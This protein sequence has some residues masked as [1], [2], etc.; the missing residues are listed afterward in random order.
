MRRIPYRQQ[1]N[2]VLDNLREATE[3]EIVQSGGL[4][5]VKLP[6]HFP[7]SFRDLQLILH[8]A[9]HPIAQLSPGDYAHFAS[10]LFVLLTSCQERRYDEWDRVSW[11]DFSGAARRSVAYQKFMADGLTRTLVAARAREMSARTGGYTLLQ[12]LFDLGTPGKETDRVL[13]GPTSDVW[14]SPWHAHL[15][16]LGVNFE[17]GVRVEELEIRAGQISGVIV[18]DSRVQRRIEADWYV[19]AVPVEHMNRLANDAI[20]ETDPQLA[21]L[22][23]L[24]TRWMNGIVFFLRRDVPIVHGHV[25]YI[26]LPWSLTAIAQAQF[27]SNLNFADA[28]RGDVRGVLSVD[29]SEWQAP[30]LLSGKTAMEC[31]R[32]EIAADVLAQ[33]RAHLDPTDPQALAD[34]NVVSWF[35]DEDVRFPE[36]RKAQGIR[37]DINLEPLLVNTAGSWQYRPNAATGV[38]NLFLA[39]DYVRTFTDLATMEGANEAARRAVNGILAASGSKEHHCEVWPL[40]E[41]AVFAPARLFDRLRF[42]LGQRHGASTHTDH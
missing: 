17:L 33:L 37:T 26:D 39:A 41:P 11:W 2:G 27:W 34:D 35:L 14:I 15:E 40:Y 28:G 5:T 22:S 42:A 25:I 3:M 6:A 23:R 16:H 7:S 38:P 36:L 9:F 29:I 10:R 31:T 13:N 30:G 8:A 21:Q 19:A 4:P 18:S 24:V 12:L 1:A 32:G 20:R